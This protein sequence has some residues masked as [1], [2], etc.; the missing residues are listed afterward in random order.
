MLLI[1]RLA[2][3]PEPKHKG[4]GTAWTTVTLD[5]ALYK[6]MPELIT[7]PE[8]IAPGFCC[9]EGVEDIVILKLDFR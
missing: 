8:F 3:D 5:A 6:V 4:G 1:G 2:R 9:V 7:P